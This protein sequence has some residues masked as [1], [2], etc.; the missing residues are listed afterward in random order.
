MKGEGLKVCGDEHGDCQPRRSLL[1]MRRNEK[2]IEQ[3]RSPFWFSAWVLL[4][5]LQGRRAATRTSSCPL[6]SSP[7][8]CHTPSPVLNHHSSMRL[9]CNVNVFDPQLPPY[10]PKTDLSTPIVLHPRVK[11]NCSRGCGV[12]QQELCVYTSLKKWDLLSFV[13]Q[14]VFSS[15]LTIASDPLSLVLQQAQKGKQKTVCCTRSRSLQEAPLKWKPV[16]IAAL[17]GWWWGFS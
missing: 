3:Q 10:W 11:G 4:P 6:K 7:F 17:L 8:I 12:H 16:E 14:L 5:L 1:N 13:N 2:F 15:H 9:W